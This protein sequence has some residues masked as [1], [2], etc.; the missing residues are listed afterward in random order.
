MGRN[1]PGRQVARAGLTGIIVAPLAGMAANLATSTVTHESPGWTALT[2]TVT[3]VLTVL[4]IVAQ[5]R[6]SAPGNEPM[7]VDEAT[8]VLRHAVTVQWEREANTLRLAE[9]RR[10]PIKWRS[11]VSELFESF[12]QS[13]AWSRRF[14][15]APKSSDVY[16]QWRRRR[17]DGKQLS[18]VW[19]DRTP[20]GRLV[21]LGPPGSGKTELLIDLMLSLLR[22]E[23][24]PPE[25]PVLVPISSWNPHQTELEE[26]LENWL[27]ATYPFLG[28]S[29][30]G[31]DTGTLAVAL[32]KAR[33]IALI[34]DGFDELPPVNRRQALDRLNVESYV[35]R[36]VLLTSRTDDF[37]TAVHP[38]NTTVRHLAG[39]QGVELR[40]QKVDEIID[41]LEQNSTRSG[42]WEILREPELAREFDTPLMAVLAD[43]VYN[44][45]GDGSPEP[46]EL[47]GKPD[48]PGYLLDGYIAAKFP[49]RPDAAR[50]W[51][52]QLADPPGDRVARPDITWWDLGSLRLPPTWRRVTVTVLAPLL[53]FCWTAF[54]TGML[55]RWVFDSA[56]VGLAHGLRI[57]AAGVLCYGFVL[58]VS[59]SG[60]AA[61]MAALGVYIAGSISGGY[62]LGITAG[63]AGGFSW[64][65]LELKRTGTAYALLFG[66]AAAAVAAAIRLLPLPANLTQ[67]F[68]AGFADGFVSGWDQDVNG[69]IATGTLAAL[70]AAGALRISPVR[71]DARVLTP[72]RP[73]M[74]WLVAGG[75]VAL[76]NAWA[77][78]FRPHASHGW[79]L[80]PA[81]G[82]AIGLAVWAV[83]M[84][85]RGR[86][87]P[88]L[89]PWIWSVAMAL[90]AAA[91]GVLAHTA[92]GDVHDGWARGLADGIAA[93][94]IVWLTL[95]YTAKDPSPRMWFSLLDRVR[96]AAPA[97]LA[98]IA[99]T[100]LFA[101][102]A[103]WANAVVV[104]IGFAALVLYWLL[105]SPAQARAAVSGGTVPVVEAGVYALVVMALIGGLAF[106]FLC[107]AT[108]ALAG[109][110]STEISRRR[111][112]SIG[113]RASWYG[114]LGGAALGGT[115]A[116]AAAFTRISVV[117][118][119]F[120]WL[121]ATLATALAF[122]AQG[123]SATERDVMVP[124]RLLQLD[125]RTFLWCTLGI[126]AAISLAVG[127]RA[128][129]G[130]HRPLIG[131]IAAVSTFF[132]YG[133]TAGITVAAAQS[134]YGIAK[135]ERT[136]LAARGLLPWT[137][138]GFLDEACDKGVLSRN[139]ASYR[140]RH[141]LLAERLASRDME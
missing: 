1:T 74:P 112:P 46:T 124:R 47:R 100:V 120:I 89:R 106:G 18:L 102:S 80:A 32:L 21:I 36:N 131:V 29:P 97:V 132:T 135:L 117:W 19:I 70:L 134:R 26:W 50:R 84:I 24:A 128:T 55:N 91:F 141:P 122:G 8:E 31:P 62:E 73:P 138:I 104:F 76:V 16:E 98:A 139:G 90:A 64:R 33:R 49:E 11:A 23:P 61:V 37:R 59:G 108:A 111:W 93:G 7:K 99:L 130:T 42:R 137:F 96:A 5:Y 54:S 9:M 38:K 87:A 17:G 129:A 34:L 25:V 39:A 94:F 78:G 3:T 44:P 113:L 67:G 81:D 28:R 52:T 60:R 140:F 6:A 57:G 14:D 27:I 85:V 92:K 88:R 119:P 58:F 20:A 56:E 68:V 125:R 110:V 83:A 43:S 75:L 79:L 30:A 40:A 35:L 69:W 72:P 95:H 86:P 2:W 4:L 109:K 101:T 107:G 22:R 105:R 51:L 115:A 121:S 15:R 123:P 103:G 63:L 13:L 82:L 77:D 10:L 53:V 126:A 127:V 45:G 48:V 66:A 41:Y 118:L 71:A 133:L 116:A 12:E 136:L 65:P 114:L